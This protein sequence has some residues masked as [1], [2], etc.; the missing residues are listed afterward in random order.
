MLDRT[1]VALTGGVIAAFIFLVGA[2]L[3]VT[4]Y[5]TIGWQVPVAAGV[6]AFIS[7]WVVDLVSDEMVRRS[8]KE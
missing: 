1:I 7:L 5:E 8:Q 3:L 4:A 6:A 2:W